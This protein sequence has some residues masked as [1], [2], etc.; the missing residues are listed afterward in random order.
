VKNTL[1]IATDA[2]P[3]LGTVLTGTD[4]SDIAA[5][6]DWIN[7]GGPRGSLRQTS[8]GTENLM[9]VTRNGSRAPSAHDMAYA[10]L[11]ADRSYFARTGVN[12]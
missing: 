3:E 8:D 5:I 1:F 2:E 12:R 11:L 4:E 7:E 9:R 10:S 6:S